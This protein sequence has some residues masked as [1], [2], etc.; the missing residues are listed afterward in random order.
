MP[1]KKRY[2][3]HLF[4]WIFNH[5]G[6][7]STEYFVFVQTSSL[8]TFVKNFLFLHTFFMLIEK[9]KSS[10]FMANKEIILVIQV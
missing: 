2:L 5:L 6:V 7:Y 9:D 3:L 10:Q 8:F 1:A 4:K